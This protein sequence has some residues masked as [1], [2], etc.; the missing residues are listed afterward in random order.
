[1]KSTMSM[2]KIAAIEKFE[3]EVVMFDKLKRKREK[4]KLKKEKLEFL[5]KIVAINKKL[6]I[7]EDIE[8]K[9]RKDN[10]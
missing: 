2:A 8:E 7:L 6:K 5:T 4:D 9:E 3:E 10:I 1:M